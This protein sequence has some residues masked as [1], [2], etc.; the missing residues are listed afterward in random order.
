MQQ[1]NQAAA[2]SFYV[3]G[4]PYFPL[5]IETHFVGPGKANSLSLQD[6]LALLIHDQRI[7]HILLEFWIR[8]VFYVDFFCSPRLATPQV[9]EQ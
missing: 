4:A 2:L 1:E 6:F 7:D 5:D 8:A 9:W 3:V